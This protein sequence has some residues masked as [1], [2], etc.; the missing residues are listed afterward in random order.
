MTPEA[1]VQR[2]IVEALERLGFFVS[3]FDQ[4]Y[5]QDGSTRQT[6]GIPDLHAMHPGWGLTLWVEVK[7]G[8]NTPTDHQKAWIQTAREAGQVAIVAYSVEEVVEALEDAGAPFT[9]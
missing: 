8:S 5:R 9:A 6:P 2:D 3:K 1:R 7:A 4:G